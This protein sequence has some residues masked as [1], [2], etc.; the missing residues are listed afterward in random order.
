MIFAAYTRGSFPELHIHIY[1][2]AAQCFI[3][4]ID[5][6]DIEHFI[7]KGCFVQ[8]YFLQDPSIA[9]ESCCKLLLPIRG[10]Y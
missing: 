10:E 3:H 1:R 9:L 2:E 5:M 6:L 7:Y 8:A 4:G